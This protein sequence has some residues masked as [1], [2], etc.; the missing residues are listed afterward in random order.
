MHYRKTGATLGEGH[1]LYV[2]TPRSSM[3]IVTSRCDSQHAV[4]SQVSAARS[5]SQ[6]NLAP[7]LRIPVTVDIDG[8]RLAMWPRP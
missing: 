5:L 7:F 8:R 6:G 3:A 2:G 1:Q 4:Y